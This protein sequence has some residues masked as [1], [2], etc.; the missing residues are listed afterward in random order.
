M[1]PSRMLY[2][3]FLE[4]KIMG[5]HFVADSIFIIFITDYTSQS[6]S[7][8][9]VFIIHRQLN[10]T[11]VNIRRKELKIAVRIRTCV[12]VLIVASRAVPRGPINV[13]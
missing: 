11:T 10:G 7:M 6:L 2:F 5:L 8:A 13:V 12:T 9:T 3:I 4:T 1:E